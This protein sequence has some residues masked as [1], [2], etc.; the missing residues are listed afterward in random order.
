M[1]ITNNTDSLHSSSEKL[2][3][4]N[5]QRELKQL[6]FK[7]Y[8]GEL[9]KNKKQF[10]REDIGILNPHLYEYK[11]HFL[12]K[13]NSFLYAPNAQKYKK[14]KIHIARN[15]KIKLDHSS[16]FINEN[17]KLQL[18]E[19][20]NYLIISSVS[21]FK[22]AYF[23]LKSKNPYTGIFLRYMEFEDEG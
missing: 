3:L 6:R 19:Q 1:N 13:D 21:R 22:S 15:N 14:L 7:N 17:L 8:L 9:S 18:K 11:N 23:L 2:T 20:D 5:L 12:I 4:L 16:F 10:Q